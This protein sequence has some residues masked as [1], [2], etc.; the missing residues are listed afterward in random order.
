MSTPRRPAFGSDRQ[1]VAWQRE[2]NA[3]ALGMTSD[4]CVAPQCTI[5]RA[6]GR[7]IGAGAPVSVADFEPALVTPTEV[8]EPRAQLDRAVRDG[9]VL[10]RG[11]RYILQGAG[12][13]GPAAA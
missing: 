11:R 9:A 5:V 13:D 12:G 8:I 7:V 4:Y 3:V 2:C 1:L 6:D 10:M